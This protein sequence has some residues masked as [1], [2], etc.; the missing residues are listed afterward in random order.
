MLSSTNNRSNRNKTAALAVGLSL[1]AILL[2]GAASGRAAPAITAYDN[3]QV[4]IQTGN[5]TFTGGYTVTAYNTT[6]YALVTY[7]TSYPAASFELPAGS[8]IFTVSA[9]PQYTYGCASPGGVTPVEA[10]GPS[11]S[12]PGSSGGPAIIVEPCIPAYTD[13]EYGYAVE[14]VSASTTISISTRPMVDLPT[15]TISV[16]ASYANGTVAAGV[17]LYASVL[18]G[19]GYGVEYGASSSNMTAQADT[20]GT[21]SLVVPSAPVEV[22]AWSWLAVDLPVNG[23]AVHVTIGGEAVNVSVNWEPAYVGLAGSV[24]IAP[25]QTSGSITLHVQQPSY[26]ATPYGVQTPESI[27]SSAVAAGSTGQGSVPASVSAEQ[28]TAPSST[29]TVVQTTTLVEQA[30]T[31]HAAAVPVTGGYDMVL[32]TVVGALALGIASASLIIV[33][34]RQ[35][36]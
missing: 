25:P 20:S 7:Q 1:M 14:Q 21:T 8:Y 6:G 34:R 10:S 23:S 36:A 28:G 26:W 16:H 11:A 2:I 12:S 18:G 22:T 13:S 32:L 30:G 17:T 27:A 3:V 15:T 9:T 31:E 24:V 19:Q 4:L 29:A 5:S 33:R 35:D